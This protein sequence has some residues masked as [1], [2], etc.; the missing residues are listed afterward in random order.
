LSFILIGVL[1]S[2]L[3]SIKTLI[4]A[5]ILFIL[6]LFFLYILNNFSQKKR[7]MN[8]IGEESY[9]SN[10]S[11][12]IKIITNIT[13]LR[14]T[15]PISL[16]GNVVVAGFI[17]L[18]PSIAQDKGPIYYSIIYVSFFLGFIIGAVF[19]NALK[20]NIQNIYVYSFFIGICLLLFSLTIEHY[21]ALIFVLFFGLSSAIINIFDE[22]I[23]QENTPEKYMGT[24]LT[25]KRS[26]LS[27]GSP[28]G[29]VAVGFLAFYINNIN[30]LI[31]LSFVKIIYDICFGLINFKKLKVFG[32]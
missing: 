11:N 32:G 27:L 13:A 31:L 20:T 15:L 7:E 4:I 22:S 6:G 12:G 8:I 18:L 25:M 24:V 3:G 5:I 14:L 2:F 21:Y 17:A 23:Y 10:L 30:I 19:S 26:V 28:I 9:L 16:F 29:A 1:I